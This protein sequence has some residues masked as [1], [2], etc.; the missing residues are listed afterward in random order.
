[1]FDVSDNVVEGRNGAVIDV[2]EGMVLT[3]VA[4]LNGTVAAPSSSD[5]SNDIQCECKLTYR[6]VQHGLAYPDCPSA[7]HPDP[8]AAPVFDGCATEQESSPQPFEEAENGRSAYLL[9][10]HGRCRY[11]LLS[12]QVTLC[13]RTEDGEGEMDLPEEVTVLPVLDWPSGPV[14]VEAAPNVK[15]PLLKARRARLNA[16][17]FYTSLSLFGNRK[18]SCASLCSLIGSFIIIFYR[19]IK[20]VATGYYCRLLRLHPGQPADRSATALKNLPPTPSWW[21]PDVRFVSC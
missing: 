9:W 6:P 14:L 13:E 3:V 7:Q 4:L 20:G 8:T 19:T 2:C 18:P 11:L 10:E 15:R 1:M 17:N 21:A 16:T 12:K 5:V